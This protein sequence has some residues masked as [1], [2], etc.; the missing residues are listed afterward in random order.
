MCSRPVY[1]LASGSTPAGSPSRVVVTQWHVIRLGSLTVAG[2]VPDWPCGFTG[3]PF[4]SADYYRRNTSAPRIIRTR[5][6]KGQQAMLLMGPFGRNYRI[7][8]LALAGSCAGWQSTLMTVAQRYIISGG[9]GTGKTK[10]L[11]ALATQGEICC[12]E[13]SRQ[14]I[15]EQAASGGALLPWNDLEAFAQECVRRMQAQAARCPTDRRVFLDRGVPDVAGY[16]RHGGYGV[17]PELRTLASMYAP[18]MFFAPAWEAIYV[19]DAERPQTYQESVALG[20][21]IRQTY[22]DYGFRVLELPRQAVD[23]R[24]RYILETLNT[25]NAPRAR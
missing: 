22:Q 25:L 10:V 13:V 9:P 4:H 5:R 16:L 11:D 3:F 21:H 15:R 8:Q 19:N 2:A 12:E 14:L 17:P 18:I 1:G 6:V 24:V 20:A 7:F 23:A